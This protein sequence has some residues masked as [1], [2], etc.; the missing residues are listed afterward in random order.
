MILETGKKDKRHKG[1]VMRNFSFMQRIF[2][3]NF[4]FFF[5]FYLCSQLVSYFLS[6]KSVC[7]E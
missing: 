6:G 2:F 5:H 4:F 7:K 3:N 1:E